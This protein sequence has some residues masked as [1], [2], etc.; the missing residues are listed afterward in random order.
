MVFYNHREGVKAHKTMLNEEKRKWI[1]I[2][3]VFV[4]AAVSIAAV[5][6]G[7]RLH[8]QKTQTDELFLT[9]F[10]QLINELCLEFP[11]ESES[12]RAEHTQKRLSTSY[13]LTVLFPLTSYSGNELLAQVFDELA[14]YCKNPDHYETG[15]S[16]SLVNAL[17]RLRHNLPD[18]SYADT[19]L[20]CLDSN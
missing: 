12:Y 20:E 10:V 11:E 8:R 13:S 18:D 6:N 3:L 19:V 16:L 9:Q 7:V 14:A 2:L 4:F 17:W 5:W 15:A 1:S